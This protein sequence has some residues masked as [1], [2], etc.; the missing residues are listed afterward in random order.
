VPV[1]LRRA[2]ERRPS[3]SAEVLE[4]FSRLERAPRGKRD[5][6]AFKDEERELARR[7]NLVDEWWR[8]NSVLDRSRGPCHPPGYFSHTDWYHVRKI[9]KALL[10]AA[11]LARRHTMVA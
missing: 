6:Q 8:G 3:F 11:G 7:L 4:L 2:K 5:S 1:K 10:T 9:R